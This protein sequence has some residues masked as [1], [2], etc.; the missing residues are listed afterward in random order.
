DA[1]RQART[2]AWFDG[3]LWGRE[4]LLTDLINGVIKVRRTADSQYLRIENLSPL[5]L[6]ALIRPPVG[7]PAAAELPPNSEVLVPSAGDS[8]TALIEWQ[9]IWIGTSKNLSTTHAVRKDR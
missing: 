1:I 6:K 8:D 4:P 2:V 7:V 5:A 9:N 3:M